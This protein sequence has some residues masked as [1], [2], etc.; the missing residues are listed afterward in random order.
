MKYGFLILGCLLIFGLAIAAVNNKTEPATAWNGANNGILIP[1]CD[2]NGPKHWT[3][4]VQVD[5][6]GPVIDNQARVWD[7]FK[8]N[9]YSNIRLDF[10]GEFLFLDADCALGA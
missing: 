9:G 8:A 3:Y 10:G 6:N 2:T 7:A 5:L 4:P 1:P